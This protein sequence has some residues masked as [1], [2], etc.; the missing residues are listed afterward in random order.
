MQFVRAL[1]ERRAPGAQASGG[2]FRPF[3][4]EGLLPY[5]HDIAVPAGSRGIGACRAT[6]QGM[7]RTGHHRLLRSMKEAMFCHAISANSFSEEAR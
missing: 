1:S 4:E 6:L 7:A 3:P 5:R 2:K